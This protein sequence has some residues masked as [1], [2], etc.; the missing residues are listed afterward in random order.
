VKLIVFCESAGRRRPPLL[1]RPALPDLQSRIE[2]TA[3]LQKIGW[4]DITSAFSLLGTSDA[5][6]EAVTVP[7]PIYKLWISRTTPRPP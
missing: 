6:P 1:G 2:H 5:E 3:R 4:L 7:N